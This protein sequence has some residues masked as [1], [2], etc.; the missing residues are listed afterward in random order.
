MPAGQKGDAGGMPDRLASPEQLS[1]FLQV[2]VKTIY[3]WRSSGEGPP[4][5]KVGRH[6]RFRWADIDEWCDARRAS[7]RD[8][9]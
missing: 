6:L 8:V 3:R 9:R 5:I 7:E 1:A 2:P 4:A